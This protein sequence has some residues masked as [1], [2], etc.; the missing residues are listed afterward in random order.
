M[1]FND[2]FLFIH[3][4]KTA[5][6]AVGEGL[7]RSLKGDVHLVS[8]QGEHLPQNEV[9]IIDG[10]RHLT[11]KD[12]DQFFK[13]AGLPHRLIKFRKILAM[14]RNP[15]EIEVSRFHYLRLGRE[16]DRGE[17]QSLAMEGDFADFVRDS[18]WWFNY[19]DYYTVDGVTPQ[20]LH[21][22]R[23]EGFSDTISTDFTSF[24]QT[25]FVVEKVNASHKTRYGDYYDE[26]LES[27]VYRKY[28]WLFDEGHYPRESFEKLARLSVF[29]ADDD[30]I[31]Y[32]HNKQG[33]Y[34]VRLWRSILLLGSMQFWIDSLYKLLPF[35]ASSKTA[36]SG[37]FYERFGFL[38]KGTNGYQRWLLN[39]RDLQGD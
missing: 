33:A 37:W 32:Y 39:R 29:S 3:V 23:Y 17:A 18:T 25:P 13:E 22:V 15:Y 24:F 30:W 38:L 7:C 20:N 5:G 34:V 4:P 1:I 8:G 16:W 19:E 2:D 28:Q 12:A 14:V 11:L 9:N 26:E 36:L 27:H 21:I 6:I 10:N 31:E 35:S